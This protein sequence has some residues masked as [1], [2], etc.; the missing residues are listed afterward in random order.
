MKMSIDFWA[1][2]VATAKREGGSTRA[3]AQRHGLSLAAL[4]YWQ[5]KLK[6]V[7]PAE[8]VKVSKFVALRVAD[9]GTTQRS[10]ACTLVMPSGMRLEMTALPSPQWLAALADTTKGAR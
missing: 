4:Y 8:P 3:Y 6:S 5:R 9:T 2:H 1:G 10:S 7:T